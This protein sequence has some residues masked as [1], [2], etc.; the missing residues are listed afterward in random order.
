MTLG[1]ELLTVITS[2]AVSLNT[3][4]LQFIS[5]I[6]EVSVM[7][8]GGWVD[9]SIICYL[10]QMTVL[11]QYFLSPV[12]LHFILPQSSSILYA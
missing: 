6:V 5:V 9:G 3:A 10:V 2:Q 12:L 8:T 11:L 4:V 1:W 7:A